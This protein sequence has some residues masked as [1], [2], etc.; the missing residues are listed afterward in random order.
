VPDYKK[1]AM[2]KYFFTVSMLFLLH[3]VFAQTA[4]ATTNSGKK[5]IL[6]ADGTWKFKDEKKE[7][8]NNVDKTTPEKKVTDNNIRSMP[9]E[10]ADKLDVSQDKNNT[11]IT[12][13]KSFIVIAGDQSKQEIDIS[14]QKG[15]KG[16]N[17][18]SFRLGNG[19]DCIGEGNKINIVF[20]DGSRSDLS[21]D[22]P[23]NCRGEAIV[24][25]NGPYGKKKQF[26]ELCDKKIKS[27]KVWTQTGAVQQSL[28][29]ENKE[30]FSQLLN[31]LN[32][33]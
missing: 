16:I 14:L 23:M 32:S 28:S 33:K 18:I 5:V 12:R 17:S 22:G 19:A 21:N 20:T 31:C 8:K 27:I 30:E 11:V 29:Q 9:I 6:F 1:R 13:T 10:C 15:E 26:Q 24:N 2:L 7:L 3:S 4:E 25:F